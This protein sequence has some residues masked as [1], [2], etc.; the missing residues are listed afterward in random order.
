M[1]KNNGFN[2]DEETIKKIGLKL[3]DKLVSPPQI[4]SAARVFEYPDIENVFVMEV[5]LYGNIMPQ[6]SCFLAFHGS[7]GLIGKDLKVESLKNSKV[8]DIKKLIESNI[9]G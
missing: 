7:H 8:E 2:I 6:D 4:T 1:K 3:S 5:D 9:D